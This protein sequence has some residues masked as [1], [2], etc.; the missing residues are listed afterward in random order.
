LPRWRHHAP[1]KVSC[2]ACHHS[3]TGPKSAMGTRV[4]CPS[5]R[6]SFVWTD[7]YHEGESFVVYD[8]ETTGLDPEQDEFTSGMPPGR[9][10]CF[11]NSPR[12]PGRPL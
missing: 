6:H 2:P 4:A 11:A 5:C 8:L 7:C 3:L 12:G 1:M 9:R 10:R